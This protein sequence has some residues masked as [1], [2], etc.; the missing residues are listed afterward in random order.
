V[1]RL[2][3]LCF[4]GISCSFPCIAAAPASLSPEAIN[5][6]ELSSPRAEKN[7]ALIAKAE[8]LL[9]RRRFSPGEIDGSDGEN[10]RKAL[11]AFQSTEQL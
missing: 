10:F 3:V 5:S 8:I 2:V 7:R 4:L 1:H 11:A 6:A 9:D